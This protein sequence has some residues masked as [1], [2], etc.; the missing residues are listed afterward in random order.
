MQLHGLEM[1]IAAV[2]RALTA[3][4][5]GTGSILLVEGHA[6]EGKSTL[7]TSAAM[8]A[9]A[10]GFAVVSSIDRPTLTFAGRQL[11][12][13]PST[14]HALPVLGDEASLPQ[15]RGQMAAHQRT[16][17]GG[18]DVPLLITLDD[19]HELP[20]ASVK[21]LASL[22]SQYV[23]GPAVWLLS[24]RVCPGH[25]EVQRLF[26]PDSADVALVQV[27][28]MNAQGTAD[29][30]REVAQAAPEPELL[31][32]AQMAGGN[33]LLVVEL[34]KGLIE[35][36][37][38]AMIGDGARLS[39]S[40]LPQRLRNAV[41][42]LLWPLSSD[43]RDILRVVALSSGRLSVSRISNL[44][45]KPVGI[46]VSLISQ[47]M[48]VGVLASDANGLVFSQ[49]LTRRILASEVPPSVARHL[50]EHPPGP[51][52]RRAEQATLSLNETQR[53]IAHLVAMGLTNQQIAKRLFLSP[54][55]VN[56]HLRRIFH[57]LDIHSRAE[58]ATLTQQEREA[59]PDAIPAGFWL[60]EEGET[61]AVD[62]CHRR[63]FG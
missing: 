14:F 60:A 37:G 9:L 20:A 54:H 33:R 27:E 31:A 62:T 59:R 16:R 21:V 15:L 57:D 47:A 39:G 38:S 23:G 58:L 13:L 3:A 32:L 28:P 11:T 8:A 48:D 10:R 2:D 63:S 26:F 49:E 51:G 18:Q 55:T 56:Y 45:H 50:A 41:D 22:P 1:Q 24:R 25:A 5:G 40:C 19:L 36:H 34:V 7:L 12:Q 30:V 52:V 35:E 46:I 17:T 4:A 43:C 42:W 44:L 6:G 61:E 29:L 53:S